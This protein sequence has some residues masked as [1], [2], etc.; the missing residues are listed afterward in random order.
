MWRGQV[1]TETVL[2]TEKLMAEEQGQCSEEWERLPLEAAT[3]QHIAYIDRE[4]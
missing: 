2:G 3:K 4:H 1:A